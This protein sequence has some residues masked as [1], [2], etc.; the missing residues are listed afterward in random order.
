MHCLRQTMEIKILAIILVVLCSVYHTV[1]GNAVLQVLLNNG[2]PMATGERC[3]ST[4]WKL[5][6]TTIMTLSQNQRR[7]LLQDN[8]SNRM[9]YN[10]VEKDWINQEDNRNLAYYPPSC[11]NK[12]KGY[13]SKC[14]L[15]VNCKGYR[16]ERNN[17][18]GL[19]YGPE[20]LHDPGR[21]LY[22][23]TSCDN[24]K[25]EMNNWLNNLAYQVSLNC[26][27][28]LRAPRNMTCFEDMNC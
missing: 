16:R 25:S 17:V 3:N 15:A 11:K 9:K 2:R 12:C 28:V 8:G 22:Y 5:I 21:N 14:C 18:R 27:I 7:S 26:S 23:S 13:A 19:L 1:R 4:E 10:S 20:D 6:N 24:Q